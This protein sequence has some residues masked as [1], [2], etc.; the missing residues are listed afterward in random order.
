MYRWRVSRL[1]LKY[2]LVTRSALSLRSVAL[3]SFFLTLTSH[4]SRDAQTNQGI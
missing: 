4:Y 2:S 1:V 3:D